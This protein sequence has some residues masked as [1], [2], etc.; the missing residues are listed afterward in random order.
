MFRRSN[1]LSALH[2]FLLKNILGTVILAFAC[3]LAA[4]YF[5][6]VGPTQ[7]ELANTVMKRASEQVGSGVRSMFG[8][9]QNSLATMRGWGRDGILR[10]N[11]PDGFANLLIPVLKSQPQISVA[12]LADGQGRSI[13]VNHEREQE[14]GWV[15]HVADPPEHGA[16]QRVLHYNDEGQFL[17]EERLER[18][19]DARTRPWY[20]DALATPPNQIHWTDP[21]LFFKR[22]VIGITA[23][24]R[25]LDNKTGGVRIVAY[26]LLLSDLS[27]FTS[28]L[29]VSQNG[30]AALLTAD[31]RLLAVPRFLNGQAAGNPQSKLFNTPTEAG[32]IPLAGALEARRARG[33]AGSYSGGYNVDGSRWIARIQPLVFNNLHID[34]VTFGPMSDFILIARWHVVAVGLMIAV[35]LIFSLLVAR[36]ISSRFIKT[37]DHLVAESERIGNL[38]LDKPV[39]LSTNIREIDMLV[40]AQ[41]RMRVMLQAYAREVQKTQDVTIMAMA[42]LAEVRDDETGNHI[43]RTQH[44]VRLLAEELQ[45]HPRFAEFLTRETIDLL[46]KSAPLHDIGK[47]GIPDAILLK[48][49]RLTPEEFEIMKTHTTLGGDAIAKAAKLMEGSSSFLRYAGEIAYSHQEKWDGSGYPQGLAG[50]AIPV[51]ARLMAVADVYDALISRRVYK[52]AFS[53]ERAVDIIQAGRGTHFDPDVADAFMAIHE[54]FRQIAKRFADSEERMDASQPV[55]AS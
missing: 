16:T 30:S 49:G 19:Y 31:G 39:Q 48:P 8:G 14:T 33:G 50:D 37:V 1:G 43:C 23:T 36:L 53:H 54:S 24:S 5:T 45:T 46:F 55:V 10:L 41:E 20:A 35:V 21:Y 25:W 38:Q 2:V 12:I 15:V 13:Q 29:D 7:K 18:L 11:D 27:S 4:S 32:S 26:D 40:A 42:S 52:P 17:R 44:Y 28:Q 34:V 51:S 9:T 22:D 6:V 3:F 47:V